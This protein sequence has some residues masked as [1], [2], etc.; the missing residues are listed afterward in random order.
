M[1]STL[2]VHLEPDNDNASLLNITGDLAERFDADVIGIAACQTA[3]LVIGDGVGS[4][5]F[6]ERDQAEIKKKMGRTEKAFHEALQHRSPHLE[7]RSTETY[8]AP[9]EYI[10]RQMRS[11]DLLI[12]GVNHRGS[13]LDPTWRVDTG[14]LVMQAGRPVLIVPSVARHLLARTILVAWKD[15]RE[16]RRALSDALPL[17]KTAKRAIVVEVVTSEEA[18]AEGR[19]NVQDV[20]DWLERHDVSAE[21]L[22]RSADDEVAPPLGL[23]AQQEGADLV[24]AGAYGHTRLREWVLGGVTRNLLSDTNLCSLLSH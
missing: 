12:T 14:D 13:W 1:Y 24:V 19:K 3:M 9:T 16:T 17:L 21:P 22:V 6:V 5:A 8:G 4:A 2:M 11:A 18:I 7:W 10:V 20:A 23:I 15:T